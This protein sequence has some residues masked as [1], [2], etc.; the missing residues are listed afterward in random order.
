MQKEIEKKVQADIYITLKILRKEEKQKKKKV[1][2]RKKT[3]KNIE[4]VY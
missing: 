2:V 1:S 3:K 4:K